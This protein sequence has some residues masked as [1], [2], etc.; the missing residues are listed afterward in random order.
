[1]EDKSGMASNFVTLIACTASCPILLT[2]LMGFIGTHV[3][4]KRQFLKI[5]CRHF[6]LLFRIY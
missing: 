3:S 6:S 5:F 4:K 1:M 2:P